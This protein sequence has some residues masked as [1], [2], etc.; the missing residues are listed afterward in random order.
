VN[1]TYAGFLYSIYHIS[2]PFSIVVPKDQSRSETRVRFITRPV[3]GEELSAPHP[4]P[5]LEVHPFSAAFDCFFNIFSA[6]LYI[7][8]LFPTAAT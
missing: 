3:F 2:C 6:T 7:W 4:T 8:R 5:N 1:L